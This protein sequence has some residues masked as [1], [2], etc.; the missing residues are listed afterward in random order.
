[1]ISPALTIVIMLG[2]RRGMTIGIEDMDEMRIE[3]E[4]MVIIA[5]ETI[6]V[7]ITTNIVA[8][9]ILMRDVE[10]IQT[11]GGEDTTTIDHHQIAV[12]KEV[13]VE[14]VSTTNMMHAVK[15][16]S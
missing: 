5:E 8:E 16:K 4:D 7:G 9:D 6:E 14:I 10:D 3:E 11:R 2:L 12:E 1:M 15:R 13:E